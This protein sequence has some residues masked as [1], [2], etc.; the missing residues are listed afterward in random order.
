MFQN[1]QTLSCSDRISMHE[2]YVVIFRMHLNLKFYV[3]LHHATITAGRVPLAVAA[4]SQPD[5]HEHN[6]KL[7]VF[8]RSSLE[9]T[10]KCQNS[11]KH[12]L[13]RRQKIKIY[14]R[15]SISSHSAPQLRSLALS[16]TSNDLRKSI[17]LYNLLNK[18]NI[19]DF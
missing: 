2:Y 8:M 11:L 10:D 19:L 5:T 12:G 13:S 3:N 15:V 9:I 18:L 7:S 4:S 6:T 14:G 16:H 17:V 1:L